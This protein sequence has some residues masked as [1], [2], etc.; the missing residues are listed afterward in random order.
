M[1]D[2][3]AGQTP[4]VSFS[5][6][7]YGVAMPTKNYAIG[8]SQDTIYLLHLSAFMMKGKDMETIPFS[9]ITDIQ[10]EAGDVKQ[11]VGVFSFK[12]AE[13]NYTFHVNTMLGYNPVPTAQAAYQAIFSAIS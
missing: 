5:Q 6:C 4:G 13:K 9:Q 11:S 7:F 3:L 1:K 8:V 2:R 12:A 10:F